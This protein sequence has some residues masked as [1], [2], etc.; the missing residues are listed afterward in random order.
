MSEA[1]TFDWLLGILI[2]ET[3]PIVHYAS[4]VMG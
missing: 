1:T 4:D 3:T 2:F